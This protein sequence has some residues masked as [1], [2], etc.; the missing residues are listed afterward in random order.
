L[1]YRYLQESLLREKDAFELRCVP[2]KGQKPEHCTFDW[3]LRVENDTHLAFDFNFTNF[4]QVSNE[5]EEYDHLEFNFWGA[6]LLKD[7]FG[8]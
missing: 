7:E 2:A 1:R 4:T 8:R 5:G 6:G 3:K